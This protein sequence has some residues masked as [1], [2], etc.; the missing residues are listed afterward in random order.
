M[1]VI[2]AL[3]FGLLGD[4]SG[5]VE[6]YYVRI[7]DP[8]DLPDMTRW[9]P[10]TSRGTRIS[11]FSSGKFGWHPWRCDAKG[12]ARV[13]AVIHRLGPPMALVDIGRTD[14]GYMWRHRD[15]AKPHAGIMVILHKRGVELRDWSEIDRAP[16]YTGR[17][18]VISQ[19]NEIYRWFE[20]LTEPLTPGEAASP[21]AAA[22]A[23][24]G[25]VAP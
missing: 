8:A 9:S 13:D 14:R 20:W 24:G 18:N 19:E 7:V 2:L 21:P 1:S 25:D 15:P 17:L 12:K 3:V 4:P 11:V 6:K 22:P 5:L 10:V 23:P 16:G